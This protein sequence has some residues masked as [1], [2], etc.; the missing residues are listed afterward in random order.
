LAGTGRAITPSSRGSQ[1][2][3]IVGVFAFENI[4]MPVVPERA[5]F[6]EL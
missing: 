5:D 3:R 1:K 4:G 6:A 2:K